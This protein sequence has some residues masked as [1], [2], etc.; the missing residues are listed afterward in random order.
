VRSPFPTRAS[1]LAAALAISAAPASGQSAQGAPRPRIQDPAAE[2]LA[3]GEIHVRAETQEKVGPGHFAARG[4]VDVKIGELRFQADTMDVYEVPKPDGSIG[5]RVVAE[6]NV[7]FLR[8]EERLS[9]KRLEMDDTGRG[10]L[11]DAI[12]FVEPGVFV[13]GRRIERLD[14]KQYKVEGGKFSSCAQPNPRW[15]FSSSSADI[16]VGDRIIA[17]NAVFKVKSV[18]AFYV[19][20]LYYPIEDDQR[21]TGFLFPH[22]GYSSSR[23]YNVGSG[24]FWAMGRSLDQTF[25]ADYYSD[26]GYGLGHEF[27]YADTAPSRG[28]FR[29]Y[30]YD[31]TKIGGD[32]DWDL[33]WNALQ[34]LPGNVRATVNVRQY[35]NLLFQQRFQDNFYLAS[36]RTRRAYFGLQRNFGS[37]TVAASADST[38][39]YFGDTRRV[40]QHLPTFS[41]R[42]FPKQLGHTGINFG[43]DATAENLGLGDETSVSRYSRFDIAPVLSYPLSVSFLQFTPRATYRYTRWGTSY[44]VDDEGL[45][46]LGGSGIGRSF[47]EGGVDLR[48]PT[49]SR[50]FNTPGGFYTDRFKHVIGP[51]INWTYRTRVD[52]FNLIPKFDGNDYF[53]GTNEVNF[54]IVQRFLAKRPSPGGGKMVPYEFLT[55]RVYQTYY[56]KISEGQNNFDPNYSSSAFGPAGAEHL[57][58]LV[59]RMR[60]RPTPLLNADFLLEYDVNFHQLRRRSVNAGVNGARGSLQVGWSKSTR[61]AELE[62]DRLTV[63]DTLNGS[64][65]VQLVPNKLTFSTTGY[66]DFVNHILYTIQ[67][68]L[69]YDV[70]CCGFNAEY[71][72]YDFNGRQERQ[73]RFSIDLAN[74]GSIG[75]FNGLDAPFAQQG[76][77]MYR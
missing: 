59:S 40:N 16:K 49:F 45:S 24:F 8:G 12:G 58:P 11:E 9:A 69:R 7:V 36:S 6:G 10:W 5:H 17:R 66:Y 13:E 14:D 26:L 48:G 33:D 19:P 38:G 44:T 72:R 52:E 47:F 27:R 50:V 53:L 3:Q 2:A 41:V 57:S 18:P 34:V 42:R 32:W 75:N 60:F 1:I 70:Q 76:L 28:T 61:L 56:V 51:E 73:F 4:F 65:S 22:F 55:W 63:A 71:I 23:G 64:A 68:R 31:P 43:W 21:S 67:G 74:V 20:I 25:Y 54:G 39:T 77:G 29:T 30:V 46:S 62:A 35:S 37:I 15:A